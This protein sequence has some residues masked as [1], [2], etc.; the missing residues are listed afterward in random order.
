MITES[1]P[2]KITERV[3][4]ERGRSRT[5]S[6]MRSYETTKFMKRKRNKGKLGENH[7]P[8]SKPVKP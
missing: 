3:L 2:Q 6:F 4:S 8:P 7:V 1:I 5:A